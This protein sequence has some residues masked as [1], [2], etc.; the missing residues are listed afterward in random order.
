MGQPPKIRAKKKH[1]KKN[2]SGS[3]QGEFSPKTLSRWAT[4]LAKRMRSGPRSTTT[5]SPDH[6]TVIWGL[7]IREVRSG[8]LAARR[9][10]SARLTPGP[11][12]TTSRGHLFRLHPRKLMAMQKRA[13]RPS[14][15]PLRRTQHKGSRL[16]S[17]R[18]LH[19]DCLGH[20]SLSRKTK[21][22]QTKLSR[23]RQQKTRPR[24]LAATLSSV[25]L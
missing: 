11:S 24:H 20:R 13:P 6:R 12:L 19:R 5:A 16:Q 21:Q 10:N 7:A 18:G 15:L 22:R 4:C 8:P 1:R 17:T 3:F 9:R 14:T 2:K 23:L 25:E